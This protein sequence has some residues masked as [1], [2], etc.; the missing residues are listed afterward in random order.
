MSREDIAMLWLLVVVAVLFT[1]AMLSTAFIIV[2]DM[3]I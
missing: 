1:A 3:L 2:R